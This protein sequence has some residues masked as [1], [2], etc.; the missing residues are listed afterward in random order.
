MLGIFEGS[1]NI[2]IYKNRMAQVEIKEVESSSVFLQQIPTAFNEDYVKRNMKKIGYESL[3]MKCKSIE[4][5][6]LFLL[7][8]L[9]KKY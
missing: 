8:G 1:P 5:F 3:K 2:E 4:Y 6:T 7:G 9:K